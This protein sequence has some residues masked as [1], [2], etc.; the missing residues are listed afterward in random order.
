MV[1]MSFWFTAFCQRQTHM[2]SASVPIRIVLYLSVLAFGTIP[3]AFAQ[4]ERPAGFDDAQVAVVNSPTTLASTPDGRLLIASQLGQIYVHRNGVLLNPPA[5]DLGSSVC[6]YRERGLSGVA[7][8]PDF[9]SN[10]FVYVAYMFN[11]LGDCGAEY[12]ATPVG[13]V[14]RFQ[15]SDNNTIDRSTE[16]VLI[17][18]VPSVLGVHNLAD[19]EFGKDGYLYIS[20]G[21]SGCDYA[22]DSGC[23]DSNNAAQDMNSLVGKILRIKSDG[24]VPADNPYTGADTVP[25]QLTG[26]SEPGTTCQEI[27]AAG[28]RNPWRITFDPNAT[29]TR[30]FINDVGESTW[31]EVNQGTAGANYGWNAREG[32]C[33]N[34]STTDCS[35]QPTPAFTPPLLAYGRSDGCAAVT[36]GAFVPNGAWTSEFDGM[37]LFGDFTCGTIFKLRPSGDGYIREPFMQAVSGSTIVDMLFAPEN[38]RTVLYYTSFRNGGEVRRIAYVGAANRAPTAAVS[39]DPLFGPSPL[40]VAFDGRASA[41]PDGDPLTYSWNFGDGS[42]AASGVTTQ[43]TYAVDG[44][45]TATLRVTDADG[46]AAT[47]SVRIDVGN[48]PPAPVILTPAAD[49]RFAVGDRINLQGRATDPED[50]PLPDSSLTWRVVRHHNTHTHPFLPPTSGNNIG[51]T[52]PGPEDLSAGGTSWLEIELTAVDSVGRSTTVAQTL[53]PQTVRLDFLSDPPGATLRIDN[54]QLTTPVS[55]T[56]WVN[57]GVAVEASSQTRPDGARLTFSSWSDGGAAAHTIVSPAVPSTYT[58]RFTTPPSSPYGGVRAAL[59]GTIQA[60]NFDEGS[61][62]VAYADTTAGNSGGQYR[63]TNVDIEESSDIGGGYNVGYAFAGEWLAY[64]VDVTSAGS[65]DIEVR[66]ASNGPGGTFHLEVDGVDRTGPLIVPDT[67]GWQNWTT[68]R[69]TDVPLTAGQQIWR[70]VM[71]TNG[72]TTAVGNFNWIRAT[73]SAGGGGGSTPFG[74]AAVALPGTLEAE[75]FDD[76]GEGVAY[77][78]LDAGNAGNDHSRATDVDIEFT[79]DPVNGD[80]PFASHS[81]LGWVFA[82]EW[83][84]Y[85]VNV[86]TSGPYNLYV[87]VAS[88]G[89][90]GTFHIEV[91]GVDKTGSLTVP[92]TGGWSS[93]LSIYVPN[94]SLNAGMQVWR[95]VMDTNGAST[96]VGNFNWIAVTTTLSSPFAAVVLPGTIEAENFDNGGEGVAYHDLSPGNSGGQYRVTD[97]DIEGTAGTGGFNLGWAFAGEWLKYTVQVA[98]ADT[99]DI[100]VRVASNGA[101]GT[102]H[103][104]VDGIDT[105]GPLTVPDTGAWQTWTTIRATGVAVGGGSRIL[106]MVMDTNGDTTAVGN[107]D[108][109]RLVRRP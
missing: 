8:D 98:S 107:F 14:S 78:D 27:F 57:Y 17:D 53:M 29:G 31:E 74:G 77:H 75:N 55:F 62:G 108:Y 56:A 82:G 12:T 58:A 68:I 93:W 6:T 4:S 109:I 100:E 106:R 15:L 66:V 48:T 72:T 42:P 59:P 91:D 101:G 43:H 38:G 64:A 41:D 65:Y 49:Y 44:T 11:K 87:R 83:L 36:G 16:R 80:S 13:R 18:N 22:G 86:Q 25:C 90:G 104:E 70:L 52:A 92:D 45:Y 94:V 105:T 85:T 26:G 63:T 3:S 28:L 67:R 7:V 2:N 35:T 23:F 19:L 34:S 33:A 46:Q 24:T 97:V 9:P 61:A 54:D 37:Y 5:L 30:F 84:N 103:I 10:H 96:A 51:F 88:N 32:F 50:G 47:A 99:Y 39:A 21:D 76:G 60:E 89:N 69:K 71:D 73:A 81:S 79:D 20:I 40:D 95:L 102:F 1:G